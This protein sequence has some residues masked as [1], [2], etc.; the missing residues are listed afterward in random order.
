MAQIIDASVAIAW[1]VPAQ[2]TELSRDALVAV[3]ESGGHVPP[4]FWFEVIHGLNR[5]A[6]RQSVEPE[7]IDE[8]LRDV[9]ALRLTIQSVYVAEEMINL[10]TLAQQYRLNIYDAAY[11]ELSMRLNLPLATQDAPLA[12]AAISAGAALFTP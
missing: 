10:R 3:I 4:Q 6:R 1:C 5:A 9:V 2:A 8:F 11:L 7:R 12:R